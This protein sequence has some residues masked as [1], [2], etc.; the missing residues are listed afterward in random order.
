MKKSSF[1]LDALNPFFEKVNKFSKGQR[2]GICVAVIVLMI[3]PA[4]YF[5]YMPK[6]EK[7]GT[8]RADYRK[9]TDE[10]TEAKRRASKLNKYKAEMK[11]VEARFEIAKRALPETEEIPSLLTSISRAGQDSDLEFELFKPENEVPEGFYSEIPVSVKVVG[12]YH[13]L[14]TFFDKLSR[15][16][17]IVNVRDIVITGPSGKKKR[18]N[19]SPS[20]LNNLSISC[21]AVTYKFIKSETDGKASPEGKK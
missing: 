11:K 14:V 6:H 19:T 1:S 13:N 21:S 16:P 18:K 15:L 20:D 10:L 2:I 12:K 8:L 17:R 5:L 4:V 3:A 7:I 9:L